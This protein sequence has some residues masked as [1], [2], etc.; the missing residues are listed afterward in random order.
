MSEMFWSK[1]YADMPE[2]HQMIARDVTHVFMNHIKF[3]ELMQRN[4][5]PE[6]KPIVAGAYITAMLRHTIGVMGPDD[7]ERMIRLQEARDTEVISGICLYRADRE[8]W[9]GAGVPRR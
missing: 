1:N 3:I 6:L 9:V 8:E 5:P 4:V 7:A 2:D